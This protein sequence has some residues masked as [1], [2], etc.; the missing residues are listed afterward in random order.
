MPNAEE[1]SELV[2]TGGLDFALLKPIDTQF[3]VSLS[4]FEW[5]SLANFVFA[6][7]ACSAYSLV[8][9][10]YTPGLGRDPALS[11]LRRSAAWRFSTA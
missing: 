6:A 1:F 7:A 11:V 8:Q 2:R 3:L 4:K 9:I 10:D 5:S